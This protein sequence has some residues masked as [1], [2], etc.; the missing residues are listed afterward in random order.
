M[1]DQACGQTLSTQGLEKFPDA[2]K[3]FMR[4]APH[5]FSELTT[6]KSVLHSQHGHNCRKNILDKYRCEAFAEEVSQKTSCVQEYNYC[7]Y[8]GNSDW[9]NIACLNV[10]FLLLT[11]QK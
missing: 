8:E 3:P 11:M 7:C 4:E 1:L 2:L 10:L 6:L 5:T 9:T